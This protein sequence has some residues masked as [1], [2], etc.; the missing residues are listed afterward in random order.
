LGT[1]SSWINE[2]HRISLTINVRNDIG[3]KYFI[4]DYCVVKNERKG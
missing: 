4:G 2:I 1:A 3:N